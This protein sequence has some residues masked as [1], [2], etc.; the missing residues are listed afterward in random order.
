MYDELRIRRGIAGRPCARKFHL[1][2]RI[3]DDRLQHFCTRAAE[4]CRNDDAACGFGK[5]ARVTG[6]GCRVD[7]RFE[8]GDRIARPDPLTQE[9]V[10]RAVDRGDR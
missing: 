2:L 4:L 8:D 7:H 10:K 6:L 5:I 9:M 3:E 1:E